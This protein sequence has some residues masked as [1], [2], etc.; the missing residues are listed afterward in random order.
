MTIFCLT[1]AFGCQST[2]CQSY[3]PFGKSASTIDPPA[4][5]SYAANSAPEYDSVASS[6]DE[7]PTSPFDEPRRSITP[8]NPQ[9]GNDAGSDYDDYDDDTTESDFNRAGDS[10]KIPTSI[11][12]TT[13]NNDDD[14]VGQGVSGDNTVFINPEEY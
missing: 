9:Y 14:F 13:G 4:T 5:Q 11:H 10:V 7:G 8:S 3:N 1:T 12:A 6:D 2:T